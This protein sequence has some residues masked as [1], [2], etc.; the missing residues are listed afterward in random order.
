MQQQLFDICQNFEA[1]L[2]AIKQVPRVRR[3]INL[4]GGSKGYGV[5]RYAVAIGVLYFL[6]SRYVEYKSATQPGLI[7]VM[8]LG[9]SY[10]FLNCG[11][12]LL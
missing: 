11:H 9:I 4:P 7:V 12:L 1:S 6:F 3:R 10:S 2:G 5:P 8:Q